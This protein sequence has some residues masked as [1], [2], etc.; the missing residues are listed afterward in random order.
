M[1]NPCNSLN[2][3]L[4]TLSKLPKYS[5]LMPRDF[6]M[7]IQSSSYNG[8]TALYSR[9]TTFSSIVKFFGTVTGSY[10]GS[11]SG[12]FK[13]LMT[14]SLSGS[15]YGRVKSKNISASGSL[16]GSFYGRV[17]SKNISAS[18]SLS[19]SFYGSVKSKNISASG[20]LSGSYYGS[21]RS[22]NLIATGS[23]S[24]SYFGSIKSKNLNA[25]G[26][27]SGSFYG[28][29]R[30]KNIVGTGSFSGS[31]YGKLIS[32]DGPDSIDGVT[33]GANT[34]STIKGTT[35]T[36]TD[37]FI[38][39]L[40]GDILSQTGDIV[41]ENGAGG[42]SGAYFYGT[43]SYSL[44][45]GTAVVNGV[46]DG[47]DSDYI[48]T[49]LSNATG[50]YDW[51]ANICPDPLVTAP[52]VTSS[53]KRTLSMSIDGWSGYVPVF[54]GGTYPNANAHRLTSS[55]IQADEFNT[56]NGIGGRVRIT[57]SLRVFYGDV[58][59]L[60]GVL[61]ASLISGRIQHLSRI[62]TSSVNYLK[63]HIWG[64]SFVTLLLSHSLQ[65]VTVSLKSGDSMDVYIK[66][67]DNVINGTAAKT[68][69]GWSGSLNDG[70][71]AK[72]KIY[73]EVGKQI[74]VGV[75]NHGY[76]QFFN[77]NG[78]ILGSFRKFVAS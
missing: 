60:G 65:A 51:R 3:Q 53:I 59:I 54:K 33:I 32:T 46:P 6:I 36:A 78:I 10:T 40:K 28:R 42:V 14:G 24:G 12:S 71:T 66:V 70:V 48:L 7:T 31:F 2:V 16:S 76:L 35:I 47:G 56:S 57:G 25:T 55:I 62:I 64:R 38:G 11:F 69:K 72:T 41:L 68:I 1:S 63:P 37:K 20:S 52:A 30:S 58:M 29:V 18:G 8:S 13:G 77:N 34:P 9:R 23:L 73:W 27:L 39:D 5:N 22:K 44:K 50:D 67:G 43:S 4:V 26:S 45:N 74:T 21:V 17:K 19:G 75:L 49:K 15:F 61:S